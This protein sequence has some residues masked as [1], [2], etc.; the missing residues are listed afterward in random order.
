MID[1]GAGTMDLLCYDSESGSHF[2]SVARSP[3]I[4]IAERIN[5]TPGDLLLTG[6]EMGGGNLSEVLKKRAKVNKVIMTRSA[7]ATLSHDIDKILS[8]DIKVIDDNDAP[9]FI[10]NNSY[11]H[12]EISDVD[13]GRIKGI[14]DGLGFPFQFDV[15]A[16]CAQD[17]GVPPRGLSHLDFR[18][19]VFRQ[20]LEKFPYAYSL[21]YRDDEI[22]DAM[23]RLK[24][25]AKDT[26]KIPA[27]EIYVM[28]SGMAAILGTSLDMEGS[29]TE[30]K[31]VLDIATSH[32][33]GAAL[34]G[35]EICGFFEYHTRDI[36]LIKLE[37]LIIELAEGRL[38]HKKILAEG[39]HGAYMRKR[40]G[41]ES[42]EMIL[43]TGPK[44]RIIL[45]SKLPIRLGAP[46]GDN[47]M[48]GTT[49]LLEAVRIR[50]NLVPFIYI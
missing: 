32:T 35:D 33:V 34:E 40:L 16:I 43:A 31:I 26:K 20:N 38:E 23:N 24:S 29:N 9:D 8:S 48:T 18:H 22:P 30:R 28:D 25:I 19:N 36:S 37:E 2:K 5:S 46:F 14:V 6:C 49:G 45:G 44:R 27:D 41:F 17:H 21:L 4:E 39:G 15:A 3:V 11:S 47:M 1:I 13:L 42:I 7:S 10:E 12:L 50:K